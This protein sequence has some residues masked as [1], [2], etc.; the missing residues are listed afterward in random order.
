MNE[1][2]MENTVDH[3]IINKRH[4]YTKKGKLCIAYAGT[5]MNAVKLLW[6]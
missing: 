4:Q 3:K 6:S 1:F 5:A 2:V